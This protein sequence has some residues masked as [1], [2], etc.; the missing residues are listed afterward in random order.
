MVNCI[1]N[2]EIQDFIK[3]PEKDNFFI[4]ASNFDEDYFEENASYKETTG[5]RN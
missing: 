1:E 5:K 2:N 3:L 4:K